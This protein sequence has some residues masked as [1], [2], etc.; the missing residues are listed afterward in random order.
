[1]SN[2][3]R[4]AA[5]VVAVGLALAW[6]TPAQAQTAT[7]VAEE[8]AQMRAQMERMAQRIDQLEG[9]LAQAQAS[10]TAMWSTAPASIVNATA[11]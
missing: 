5:S 1:M 6:I 2:R 9:Q 3:I 10:A 4:E 7:S 8:L 11:A